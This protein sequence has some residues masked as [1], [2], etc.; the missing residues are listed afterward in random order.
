MRAA[1][2]R[3]LEL[4]FGDR[5]AS[6]A[7]DKKE[8]VKSLLVKSVKDDVDTPDPAPG[9]EVEDLGFASEEQQVAG[10]GC[11]LASAWRSGAGDRHP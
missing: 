8:P 11:R 10:C 1:G 5:P 6:V 9:A 3:A 2:F 7:S 4:E